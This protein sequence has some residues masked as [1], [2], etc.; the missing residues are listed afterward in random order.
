MPIDDH[1]FD[2]LENRYK[3]EDVF[4][5]PITRKILEASSAFEFIWPLNQ[6][7]EK[8]TGSIGADSIDRIRIGLE[9]C[10]EEVRKLGAE[11]KR[12]QAT[13]SSPQESEK[14]T[15]T[16]KDLVVDA[17][18]KA[19]STRSKDRIKRIG[20]IL[21]H[22]IVEP[23]MPD[24]DEAEEMMRTAMDLGDRDVELLRE[25]IRIEGHILKSQDFIPRF[26]AHTEWEKGS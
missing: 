10:M 3:M 5:S 23:K 26:T 11:I 22:V 20:L 17:S 6:I 25:L 19:E 1:P 2:A 13:P 9:A 15:E 8:I 4:A 18:R 12:L 16:L 14:R 7:V 24:G 21:A